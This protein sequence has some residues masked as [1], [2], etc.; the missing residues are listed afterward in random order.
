MT[1]ED[2]PFLFMTSQWVTEL[3]TFLSLRDLLVITLALE[4]FSP[5]EPLGIVLTWGIIIGYIAAYVD[6]EKKLSMSLLKIVYDE[7]FCDRAG[8]I[9]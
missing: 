8:K 6:T 4:I 7:L 2:A 9:L 1:P 3:V 5:P